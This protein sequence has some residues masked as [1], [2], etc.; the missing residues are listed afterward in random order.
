[1]ATHDFSKPVDS[2]RAVPAAGAPPVIPPAR[3][4]TLQPKSQGNRTLVIVLACVGGVL[5]FLMVLAVVAGFFFYRSHSPRAMTATVAAPIATVSQVSKSEP[6]VTHRHDR[7][8]GVPWSIHI[9]K[10]DRTRKDIA[11]HAPLATGTVLGVS[12]ISEQ[13]QA[14]SPDIGRAIAGVNGDFYERDNATYAGDP[15]GLQIINGELVSSTSTAAV[16]FDAQNNPHV[17]DVKQLPLALSGDSQ[18]TRER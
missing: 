18:R 8:A 17:D 1:M 11:F 3:P 12:L 15:R 4:T 9:V 16:W 10:V 5:L 6:G 13:A 2:S 14:V 7:V